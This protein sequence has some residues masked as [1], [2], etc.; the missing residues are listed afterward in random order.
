MKGILKT[1]G[2]WQ[3]CKPYTAIWE[4]LPSLP[5]TSSSPIE[6]KLFSSSSWCR[7]LLP[8]WGEVISLVNVPDVFLDLLLTHECIINGFFCYGSSCR[9]WKSGSVELLCLFPRKL[10]QV[11][12]AWR[13]LPVDQ[14]DKIILFLFV[15][16][17]SDSMKRNSLRLLQL[18]C[19]ENMFSCVSLIFQY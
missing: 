14:K 19:G 18:C 11:N 7:S 6:S 16:S 4:F 3:C 8:V 9:R 17:H 13:T 15:A 1:S 10:M 2:T 12:F 5:A